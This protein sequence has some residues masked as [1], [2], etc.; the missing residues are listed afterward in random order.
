MFFKKCDMI[1]PPITLSFKGDYMHSSIFSGILTIIVYIITLVFTIYY[2]L[3]FINKEKPTAYFFD[4]FIKEAGKFTFNSSSIFHYLYLINK[5]TQSKTYF[6]FDMIR[7]I[8]IE[9]INIE[10][11]Y[12][13]IDLEDIPHWIY[14][15]YKY[16]VDTK[17]INDLIEN[18]E[19]FEQSVCIRKYYNPNTKK[20]YDTTDNENFIWPSI[21][22]GM[23]NPNSTF[24]G[25]IIEKCKNDNLRKLLGFNNCNNND[26]IDDYIYS[27]GIILELIDH[28]SDVLNYKEPF[29]KYFYSIGN[30]FFQKSYTLNNMNFN[31]ALIKTH[32]GFFF[33]NVIEEKSYLFSQNEK[34]TMDEEIE[35]K[36]E[37]GKPVYD[38]NGEKKYKSSGIVS[39]YYFWMQNRLQYYERNYQRVQDILSEIGGLSRT[40]FI[41]AALINLTVSKYITLLDT[42]EFIL[43]IDNKNYYNEKVNNQKPI[44]IYKKDENMFPPKKVNFNNSQNGLQ[45]SS[46]IQKFN[47]DGDYILE[48]TISQNKYSNKKILINT[49]IAYN[50]EENESKNIDIKIEKEKKNYKK[51]RNRT[52]EINTKL[53]EASEKKTINKLLNEPKKEDTNKQIKKQNFNWFKYIW[54][55]ICCGRNNPMIS[56]Y[57]DYRTKLISEESLIHGQLDIFKLIKICKLEE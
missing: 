40:V 31:P 48:S 20:Y 7:I 53:K 55:K 13:S 37:E 33:D 35:I 26:I 36:D 29:T 16:D 6:D 32:N 28:Y 27:N 10:S 45:Q 30:L 8:G 22:H 51:K 42:E 46:N 2:A 19:E 4:R 24:Y 18:K 49:Y 9:D 57:E 50:K 17:G 38:E 11:Y 5:T 14:G 52:K 23:S 21:E 54:Y 12:S 15:F 41:I 43:S 25:I 47:K 1:S 39:S 44:I 34:V 3:Q 56:Y